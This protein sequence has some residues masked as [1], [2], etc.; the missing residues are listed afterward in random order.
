MIPPEAVARAAATSIVIVTYNSVESI[1]RC[2]AAIDVL[3]PP[4]REVIVIDNGSEDETV[5]H[6]GAWPTVRC[7]E[8]GSNLGFAAAANCGARR[9]RGQYLLFLNPDAVVADDC[10]GW[11]CARLIEAE[12]GIVG[13]KIYAEDGATLQHVGGR[14][15]WNAVS[16]HVGRG[17][18]DEGQYETVG[19]Q[20]YVSGATLL[21]STE[22]WHRLGGFDERFRPLYYEDADL[23]VRA[24]TMG[25]PVVLEPR[26][27]VRHL[28]GGSSWVGG[29]TNE[30]VRRPGAQFY[31]AYHTNRLRFVLKHYSVMGLITRFLPGEV[32]WLA[33][34]GAL[35]HF[36]SLLRAYCHL[37]LRRP[38]GRQGDSPR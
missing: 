14:L 11:M 5:A 2:L 7:I 31:E 9:A 6:V 17:E 24:R 15:R 36:P 8:A 35:G 3:D 16:E 37:D 28:E 13:C 33:V 19:A 4:A 21:V 29:G 34:G 32:F 38:P 22:D 10:L 26:A 18:P 25:L 30:G 1:D 27:T 20:R 12:G 23:C